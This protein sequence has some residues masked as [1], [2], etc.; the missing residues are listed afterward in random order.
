LNQDN[1]PRDVVPPDIN[2][3]DVVL[4]CLGCIL[5]QR[6]LGARVSMWYWQRAD[7]PWPQWMIVASVDLYL[8]HTF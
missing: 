4:I 7:G 8:Y 2:P 1:N 3:F 5:H 6:A